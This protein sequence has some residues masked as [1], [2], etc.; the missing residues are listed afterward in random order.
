[1]KIVAL[2]TG[3]SQGIP[4]IGCRCDV[5]TSDDP[6]DRRLRTSAYIEVNGTK[7]LIDIG[8]D[9]RSQ[10]LDNGL[11]DIDAVLLTHEHNDHVIGLD[12]IRAVNFMQRKTIPFYM[13]SRVAGEIRKRFEYAF[14]SHYG[15]PMISLHE[16]TLSSFSINDVLIQ[17]LR[18]MHGKLPILGYRI[19]DFA[20]ITDAKTISE[21][22]LDQ[23]RDLDTLI[24]NALRKEDHHSHLT[25][26]ECLELVHKIN[27][28]KTYLTHI[29]HRMGKTAL[30]SQELP[31]NVM[32]LQD[33]QIIHIN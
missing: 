23:L 3:T 5:C 10:F 11:W 32:P 12:D 31:A 8:P 17:P 14:E 18:I 15:A 22:T 26:S 21:T 24:I 9:F 6:A 2:G 19:N 20:Y 13:E 27:A 29:S 7:L 16:I 4:V 30:W 33:G 1:M 28:K 25:L